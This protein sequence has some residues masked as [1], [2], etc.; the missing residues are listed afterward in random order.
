MFCIFCG[1][2]NAD[3]NRF[4]MSCGQPIGQSTASTATQQPVVGQP[5]PVQPLQQ[6]PIQPLQQ[7]PVQQP[8]VQQ[9]KYPSYSPTPVAFQTPTL[10]DHRLRV[11]IVG[12][13][14]AVVLLVSVF[15]KCFVATYTSWYEA[16][17][18]IGALVPYGVYVFVAIAAITLAVMGIDLGVVATGV[19]ALGLNGY[20]MAI[21]PNKTFSAAMWND[22]FEFD[23]WSYGIYV[24]WAGAA[25]ILIGGIIGLIYHRKKPGVA[26]TLPVN[27]PMMV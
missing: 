23:H 18:R 8:P 10:A 9:P 25:L 20:A 16:S 14:G 5:M 24:A 3:N 6:M 2:Q 1:S 19:I 17:Y 27:P 21:A 26:S 12:I 22:L 7:S 13:V 11:N 4:C 15:L